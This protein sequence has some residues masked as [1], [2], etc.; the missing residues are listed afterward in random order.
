MGIESC[1]FIHGIWDNVCTIQ[2]M[3]SDGRSS[4]TAD[5]WLFFLTID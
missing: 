3:C 2:V 1:V 4:A 5:D